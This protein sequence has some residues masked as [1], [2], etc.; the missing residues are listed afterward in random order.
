M[1]GPRGPI[2]LEFDRLVEQINQFIKYSSFK[3]NI[4]NSSKSTETLFCNNIRLYSV[5]FQRY[6]TIGSEKSR[7]KK[8]AG[9]ENRTE[10]LPNQKRCFSFIYCDLYPCFRFCL[11]YC[12]NLVKNSL[13]LALM[14][15][16][17]NQSE[18]IILR[19]L[20]IQ[21]HILGEK[22]VIFAL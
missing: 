20:V 9:V 3:K 1:V 11:C 16:K 7:K 18:I 14:E 4:L 19:F 15:P 8:Y 2:I 13:F 21:F 22:R 17:L 10:N 6:E 5:Y 12:Q